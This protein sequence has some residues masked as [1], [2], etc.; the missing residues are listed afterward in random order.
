M[1]RD[2]SLSA[3]EYL[4]AAREITEQH[5]ALVDQ[6][7]YLMQKK[8]ALKAA[9]NRGIANERSA[10]SSILR[11]AIVQLHSGQHPHG[12][13]IRIDY[14][15]D[16]PEKTY[17]IDCFDTIKLT[18]VHK[19]PTRARIEDR[20]VRPVGQTASIGM[21]EQMDTG[22]YPTLEDHLSRRSPAYMPVYDAL[23]LA[24]HKKLSKE[25]ENALR[26][27]TRRYPLR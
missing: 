11:D 24:E 21:R 1:N 26:E 20:S 16:Q 25:Q 23:G 3:E 18:G 27:R 6:V 7:H 15:G 22:K 13:G 9:R 19:L 4:K 12:H 8:R 2:G 5:R 14:S 17:D 10:N